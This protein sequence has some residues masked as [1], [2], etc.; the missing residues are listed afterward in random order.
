MRNIYLLM[1]ISLTSCAYL[2]SAQ[3]GEIDSHT[4]THGKKFEILVS[5]LGVNFQEAGNLARAFTADANANKNIKAV[6]D[7]LALFQMGPRTGNPVFNEKY[8]DRIFDVVRDKCPS[9]NISGLMSVRETSK[10]PIVSGEIV[11]V[12]GYCHE[13]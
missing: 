12:V 5:E 2:H 3:F 7:I 1:L 13:G 10:Y 9:G 4:V 11:K 8:A 6:Q